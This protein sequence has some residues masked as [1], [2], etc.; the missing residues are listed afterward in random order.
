MR[1][2]ETDGRARESAHYRKLLLVSPESAQ[3]W[4]MF[5]GVYESGAR[6]RIDFDRNSDVIAWQ[7]TNN[8]VGFWHSPTLDLSH[9]DRIELEIEG[10]A[11]PGA[12]VD[13]RIED[14]VSGKETG[15]IYRSDCLELTGRRDKVLLSAEDF[16]KFPHFG[17]Q[18]GVLDWSRIK[19]IQIQTGPAP[20]DYHPY[21]GAYYDGEWG[22][23]RRL[24]GGSAFIWHGDRCYFGFSFREPLDLTELQELRASLR[25]GG[26][27]D[28]HL[29]DANGVAYRVADVDLGRG[30]RT[31]RFEKEDFT[32]FPYSEIGVL[33]WA[34]I[35]KIQWQIPD[36]DGAR[37]AMERIEMTLSGGRSYSI[38]SNAGAS[39]AVALHQMAVIVG[40]RSGPGVR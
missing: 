2:S 39:A 9:L 3:P 35:R 7:G 17:A 36:A 20:D 28:L 27:V 21:Q 14:V 8:Y 1:L 38:V 37:V 6:G 19:S 18:D 30:L 12:C 23:I 34:N 22:S 16:T 25:G 4:N 31:H 24:E 29:I 10:R 26:E 40:D 33:D 13:V 15:R 11:A 5:S 32:L